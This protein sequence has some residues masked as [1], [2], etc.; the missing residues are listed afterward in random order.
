[1]PRAPGKPASV[2]AQVGLYTGLG[3]ILPAG[4][5]GG[6]LFGQELDK[7]L[8]TAPAL[9][10]IIAALGTVG[11]FIEILRILSRA[12]RNARNDNSEIGPGPN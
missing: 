2:W 5:V 4:T 8:H 6:Y 1:M 11:G 3:F 9:A 10:L 12:E 7:W